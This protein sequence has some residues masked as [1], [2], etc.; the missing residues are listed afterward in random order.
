MAHSIFKCEIVIIFYSSIETQVFGAQK[1]RLI[2]T[3][4]LSTHNICFGV[5][6]F[7]LHEREI[8]HS[9]NNSKHKMH[10]SYGFKCIQK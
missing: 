4:L 8:I 10:N 7:M 6:G 9:Y 1:N 5:Y 3:V 2:A